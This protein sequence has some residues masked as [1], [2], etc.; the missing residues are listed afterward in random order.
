MPRLYFAG[1]GWLTVV[2]VGVAGLLLSI[3]FVKYKKSQHKS[4][5]EVYPSE[6][7]EMYNVEV[8]DD[9]E[10]SRE[11]SQTINNASESLPILR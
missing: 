2:V 3:V 4:D 9:D 7:N 5:Y 10:G 8:K 6:A 1:G 11:E